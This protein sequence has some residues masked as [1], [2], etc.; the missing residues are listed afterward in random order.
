MLLFTDKGAMGFPELT[1]SVPNDPPHS[2]RPR[3]H[4]R[5]FTIGVVLGS[6]GEPM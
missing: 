2:S 5:V 1:D 6:R 3:F 4:M